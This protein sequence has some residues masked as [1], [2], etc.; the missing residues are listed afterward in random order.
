MFFKQITA[1][2]DYMQ[3]LGH[4]LCIAVHGN[5]VRGAL[6]NIATKKIF[7]LS[8]DLF[9]DCIFRES[10]ATRFN[11]CSDP[12]CFSRQFHTTL[13]NHRSDNLWLN[14]YCCCC[15]FSADAFLGGERAKKI[16]MRSLEG[17][18]PSQMRVVSS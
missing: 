8:V 10:T 14:D 6:V 12:F 4:F 13:I 15:F 1:D 17:G 18:F 11:T 7:H 9:V 5:Q 2:C 16:I 3:T